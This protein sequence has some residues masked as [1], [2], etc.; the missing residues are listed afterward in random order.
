MASRT[1]SHRAPISAIDGLVLASAKFNPPQRT[2][3]AATRAGYVRGRN[4]LRSIQSADKAPS[5]SATP[6]HGTY[7]AEKGRSAMSRTGHGVIIAQDSPNA[8]VLLR[9]ARDC[10]QIGTSSKTATLGAKASDRDITASA[11]C[12]WIDWRMASISKDA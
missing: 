5:A 6:I 9:F 7:I 8:A 3:M 2:A 10:Q 1:C 11:S 12:V 4:C